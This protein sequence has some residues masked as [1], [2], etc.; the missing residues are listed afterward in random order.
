MLD[1]NPS[2]NYIRNDE[3]FRSFFSNIIFPLQQP[4]AALHEQGRYHVTII[5]AAKL[6]SLLSAG[7]RLISAPEFSDPSSQSPA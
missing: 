7:Q 2:I 4:D 1:K 5:E 3:V 6:E